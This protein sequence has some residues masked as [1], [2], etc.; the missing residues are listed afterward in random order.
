MHDDFRYVGM[1]RPLRTPHHLSKNEISPYREGIVL[2]RNI[3]HPKKPKIETINNNDKKK[4]KKKL[5]KLIKNMEKNKNN[6]NIVSI[7]NI[8]FNKQCIIDQKLEEDTRCTIKVDDYKNNANDDEYYFGKVVKPTEPMEKDG[9]YWGYRTR[10]ANDIGRVLTES[11]Y[12]DGYDYIVGTSDKGENIIGDDD[13]G[14]KGFEL[15][16]FKHLLIVF[17][18]PNGLEECVVDKGGDKGRVKLDKPQLLFDKY[19]NV[20]PY[21]GTRTIRSEEALLMTL[22]VLQPYIQNNYHS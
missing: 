12:D 3:I 7:V 10:F 4:K 16:K 15:P 6:D 14:G 22:S 20:C 9:I 11:L 17:G 19:I 2:K 1:C 18:G 5:P 21:Q 8:G 13:G